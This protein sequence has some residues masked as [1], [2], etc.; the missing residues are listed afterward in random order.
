MVDQPQLAVPHQQVGV[1]RGAIDVGQVG[2]E[3]DDARGEVGVGTLRHRVVHHRARQVIERQV[4]PRAGADQILDLRVG[5][6][7]REVG[8]ELDE[9][10]R[11]DRERRGARDFPRHELRNERL[12]TLARAAELEHVEALVVR[13]DDG[14]KRAAL[15]QRGDVAGGREGAKRH[16]AIYRMAS[17]DLVVVGAGIVGLA[18]A[19]AGVRRGMRVAVLE[20]D[21]RACLASVRNF[22]FVTVTGQAE[23][24][25]RR[26]ALRSRDV[27]A[28]VA[29]AAG[30]EVHQRGA[31]IVA[32]R[33]EALA[34]LR[35]F[36]AGPMGTGCA[37][38]DAADARA[39][40]PG[41]GPGIAGALASP[42]ELR[43][44]ARDALPRLA[45]WLESAHGATFHWS[46]AAL[47][48]EGT[49]VRH[50]RGTLEAGAVVVA[51]GA[52]VSTF[53][54]ELAQ[55]V[56]VRQCKLQM[57]RLAAP[58]FRLPGV[59]MTDLSLLR[60]EGFAMQPAAAALARRVATE[61]REALEHGIHLIVAQASDG[62]LVVG[63]SHHDA[64][65]ADPFDSARVDDLI[66]AELRAL[67]DLP[68]VDVLERW[69]G[70]YPVAR[71]QPVVR[72]A[73]GDR[74]VLVCVTSGNGMS[75]AF[76]L[77]EET[78]ETLGDRPPVAISETP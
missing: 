75:T 5:L 19:L 16:A 22:G 45:A 29:Q 7:A 52:A 49:T 65:S 37:L 51:P 66:L 10:D 28:E 47:A 68:R 1:A 9:D 59:V 50:A 41:L 73:L 54:P 39:R 60:Y 11:G 48:I 67:F 69:V 31:C 3:P 27:W 42:H 62:T 43:V 23:G 58:G 25:T 72:E 70:H 53:A 38:L 40:V 12:G 13:L 64:D 55:R 26:R 33:D 63:D 20:R 35:E 2:I 15:A 21:A 6:G 24:D 4:E 71:V 8:V 30:I 36:A 76:A 56:G 61:C 17:F 44:E 77:A 18:H 46:C 34:V 74:C 14:G 57:M 78:L 32:R